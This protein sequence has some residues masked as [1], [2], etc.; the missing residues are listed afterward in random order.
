MMKRSISDLPLRSAAAAWREQFES[1]EVHVQWDPERSLH[2][3]KLT[4]RSIQV[5][6]SRRIIKE[7]TEEWILEISDLTPT[8]K[9]IR[10]LYLAGDRRRAK[11]LLPREKVYPVADEIAMRLG[12]EQA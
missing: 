6:L 2:G 5:G 1:A 12:M 3:G 11:D 8:A 10:S 9:K 4:H 7:Y